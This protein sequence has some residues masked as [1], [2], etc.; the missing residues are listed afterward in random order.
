MPRSS[1]SVGKAR[2]D[3]TIVLVPMTGLGKGEFDDDDDD[4]DGG[5]GGGNEDECLVGGATFER[6]LAS[7]SESLVSQQSCLHIGHTLDFFV[8]QTSIHKKAIQMSCQF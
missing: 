4:G 1:S 3:T 5:D 8:S 6:S 2:D 7:P